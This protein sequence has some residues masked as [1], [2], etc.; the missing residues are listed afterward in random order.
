MTSLSHDH[1]LRRWAPL[2]LSQPALIAVLVGMFLVAVLGSLSH[3]AAVPLFGSADEIGHFDYAYEVWH[4]TLPDFYRGVVVDQGRGHTIPVQWVAQHPPLFGLILSPFVGPLTDAG[5]VLRAGLLARGVNIIISGLVPLAVVWAGR[6]MLPARWTPALSAGLVAAMCPWV[7]LVGGAIYND[8]LA[9]LVA[10]LV[11][12]VAGGALR[13][14]A[15][16]R[17]WVLLAIVSS[18]A[19]LTRL[20]LA[21]VVALGLLATFWATIRPP[22]GTSSGGVEQTGRAGRWR[23]ALAG[24]LGVIALVAATSG[25]FY[26]RN[27]QQTGSVTGGHPEWSQEHLGRTTSTFTEIVSQLSTWTHLLGL[28]VLPLASWYSFLLLLLVPTALLVVVLAGRAARGGVE[29]LSSPGAAITLLLVATTAAVLLMQVRYSM[30]GGGLMARYALP[31]I[32]PISL[33]IVVGAGALGR[34]VRLGLPAWVA[35]LIYLTAIHHSAVKTAQADEYPNAPVL[36]DVTF[37]LCLVVAALVCLLIVRISM[38]WDDDAS[39][40]VSSEPA[41]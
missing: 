38:T 28:Y 33:G 39:E 7:Y 31:L 13:R 14:G 9:A 26:W 16:R 36:S 6:R 24:S 27:L 35:T 17:T 1:R 30:G 32:L 2:R 40:L 25:W 15:D 29:V 20:S 4:G 19:M 18:L 10:T 34:L 8:V 41:E 3:A 37:Y 23:A 5:H 22:A 21:V 11:L 12:G